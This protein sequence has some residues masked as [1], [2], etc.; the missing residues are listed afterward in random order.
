MP[1]YSLK[2]KTLVAR[3]KHFRSSSFAIFVD[4][5]VPQWVLHCVCVCVCVCVCGH[6]KRFD[7]FG[8]LGAKGTVPIEIHREIQAVYVPNVVTMQHVRKW[9]REI[10][11]C[12]VSM[13][14][15]QRSGRPSRIPPSIDRVLRNGFPA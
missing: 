3:W 11:G 9:C 5:A 12:R 4:H 8:F 10:S 14:D 13:T 7:Q 1:L 15:E 2:V 6:K